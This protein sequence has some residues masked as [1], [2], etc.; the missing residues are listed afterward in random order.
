MVNSDV[1]EVGIGNKVKYYEDLG[2]YIPRAKNNQGKMTVPRG[3]KIF[4]KLEHLPPKSGAR[5]KLVCDYCGEDFDRR[6]AD[7]VFIMSKDIKNNKDACENCRQLKQDESYFD[8]HG[9]KNTFELE[10]TKIKIRATNLDRYGFENSVK[11]YLV[12]QKAKDTCME[13]YGVDNASKSEEVK[14]KIVDT[15]QERF[16][17]DN[18]MELEEYRMKIADTLSKNHSV[19]TSRQQI[20]LHRLF[21]G[22]LNYS[23]YTPILDIAFP[24]TNTYIE[25][26]GGGHNLRVKLG[27][28]TKEEFRNQELRRYHYLKGK[29]WSAIFIDSDT[30]LLP[31]DE[32]LQ[33]LLNMGK[34]YLLSGERWVK[35]DLD[36]GKIIFNKS[37]IDYDY[38]KLRKITE[39]DLEEVV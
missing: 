35:F 17:V 14:Q 25:Y 28:M 7:H 27:Q 6:Y 37:K 29:G 5:I 23:E 22:T 13:R 33:R 21:G 32:I 30:D 12:Q 15:M 3:T 34:E 18:I 2:Y 36:N 1:V 9:V 4:V 26:N 8:K 19:A 16:G 10:E 31:S 24:E 38:G 39:K 20:Y 11:N